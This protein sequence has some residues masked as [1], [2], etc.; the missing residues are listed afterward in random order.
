MKCLSA[1]R[2]FFDGVCCR[3]NVSSDITGANLYQRYIDNTTHGGDGLPAS[4]QLPSYHPIHPQTITSVQGVLVRTG[5]YSDEQRTDVDH[6][7]KDFRFEDLKT[8]EQPLQ[9]MYMIGCVTADVRVVMRRWSL[10]SMCH[11]LTTLISYTI[12]VSQ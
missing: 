1:C 8:L 9:T 7:H 10:C 5:V 12:R 11:N 4:R 2:I 6:S 3:D